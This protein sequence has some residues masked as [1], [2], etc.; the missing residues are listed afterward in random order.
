MDI[1]EAIKHRRTVRQYEDKPI[2]ADIAD[3]LNEVISSCNEEGGLNIQLVLNEPKAFNSMMAKYGSFKGVTNYIAVIGKNSPDLDEKAG[4]YGEKIVLEAEMLGLNTCWVALTYKKIPTAYTVKDGEKMILVIALGYGLTNDGGKRK[5]KNIEA[6]S[7]CTETSPEWFRKGVEAALRAPTAINQQ[8][9]FLEF[10]GEKG[11][12]AKA[13][14][15]VHAKLDLGIVKYHF[16]IGAGKDN[17]I[18]K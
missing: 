5:S 13:G 2:P 3:K 11:V 8:K 1:Y 7:N 9:F 6:V 10:D 15:G 12:K 17:F 14:V 4:Y 18:W 16:E